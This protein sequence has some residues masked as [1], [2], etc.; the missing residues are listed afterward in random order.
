MNNMAVSALLERLRERVDAYRTQAI[1]LNAKLA[2]VE[3]QRFELRAMRDQL[4]ASS[5]RLDTAFD[6]IERALT[7]NDNSA[8]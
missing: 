6:A 3:H 1:V 8:R 7:A 2:I 4:A 5:A